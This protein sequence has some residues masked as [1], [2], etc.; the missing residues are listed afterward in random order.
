MRKLLRH[1]RGSV[2]L[3]T[4]VAAIPLIMVLALGGEAGTWY[5]TKGHAQNAADA[6]AYSGALRLACSLGA[7]SCSDTP[8]SCSSVTACVSYRGK[9]FA[10][11]NAFCNAGDKST[12]TGCA[13][14]TGNTTQSVAIDVGTWNGTTWTTTASGHYVRALVGE[15]QPA[16]LS[17][18]LGLATININTQAIAKVQNP[19]QLCSLGLGRSSGSGSPASALTL[20]GS[21]NITGNGCG[22]MSDNTVKYNSTPSFSGS[23]WAVDAVGGCVNSGNCNPGVP[24]NYYMPT[25]TNPLSKFEL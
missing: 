19:K 23:G 17:S 7:V 12:F 9:Q 3:A 4:L 13:S 22:L 2:A 11:D 21:V 6:A 16:I 24:Y 1:R 25:A 5:V 14:L 10:A 18:F 20:G 15:S 8:G